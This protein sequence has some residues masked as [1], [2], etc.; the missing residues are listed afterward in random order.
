M[1]SQRTKDELSCVIFDSEPVK[2][3]SWHK[4]YVEAE[5]LPREVRE[6]MRKLDLMNMT[7]TERKQAKYLNED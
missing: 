4:T 6:R 3:P 1:V 7:P 2:M 5:V